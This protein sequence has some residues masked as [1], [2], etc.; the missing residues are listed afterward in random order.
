MVIVGFFETEIIDNKTLFKLKSGERT[1][2]LDSL[3]E[4]YRVCYISDK[5]LK[6]RAEANGQSQ[7]DFILHVLP[8]IAN[9]MSGDFGELL[10]YEMAKGYLDNGKSNLSGPK[11]WRWKQDRNKPAPHSDIL[12]FREKKKW[13]KRNLKG[14]EVIAIESKMKAVK[15]NGYSPLQ[16]AMNG[17][18]QDKLS[19]M[20]KSL[21]WYYDRLALDGKLKTKEAINKFRNP[22]LYG[23]FKKSFKAVAIIDEGLFEDEIVKGI[24]DADEEIDIWA[25]SIERLQEA[26]Q[27]V[28]KEI[29]KTVIDEPK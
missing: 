16:K 20:A 18:K 28:Y 9:I 6:K 8:D 10:C 25:I 11:K 23:E 12:L 21:D 3:P 29:P 1:K 27:T 26:Y 22:S 19:R 13:S 24:E 7:D 15:N 14:D 4:N 2:F 5:K 17:A